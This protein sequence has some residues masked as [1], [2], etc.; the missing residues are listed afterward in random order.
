MVLSRESKK[1]IEQRLTGMKR[2]V[3]LAVF[4]QEIEA[5]CCKETR[6]IAEGLAEMSPKVIVE[7]SDF[8]GNGSIVRKYGAERIPAIVVSSKE[9]RMA[10]FYG[11]PSG[12]VFIALVEAIRDASNGPALLE[13]SID[14]LES[15]DRDI[16]L[17]VF[18]S[19]TCPHCSAMIG[20]VNKLAFAS[21]RIQAACISLPDFPHLAVKYGVEALPSVFSGGAKACEGA[22]SEKALLDKLK[23]LEK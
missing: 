7:S 18:V 15:L 16:Q 20:L 2:P 6:N 5:A 12:Y 1:D 8:I 14:W 17:Q 21:D 3:T 22:V 13:E 19:P 4:T 11:T 9:G 23:K 10:R